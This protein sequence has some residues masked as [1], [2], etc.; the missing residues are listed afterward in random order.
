[1]APPEFGRHVHHKRAA[2]VIGEHPATFAHF[3]LK[4]PATPT[5]AG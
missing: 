5:P 4:L 3:S 1:M 2:R